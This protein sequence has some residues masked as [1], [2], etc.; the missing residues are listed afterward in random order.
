MISCVCPTMASRRKWLEKAIDCF[1]EQD[2]EEKEL[3]V[4][5]DYP[6]PFDLP[7]IT[8]TVMYPTT[9]PMASIG[10]KRNLGA[11]R[12][13]GETLL[14]WDDDDF[15]APNRITDQVNRLIETGKSVTGYHSLE[16]VNEAGRRWLYKGDTGHAADTSLCYRKSFWGKHP[17]DHI[18]DGAELEFKF[19]AIREGQFISVPGTG[20]MTA[21]IH[22]G[23]TTARVMTPGNTTW[24]EL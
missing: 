12:A 7:D 18:N 24:V 4:V 23:N 20:M 8:W 6:N 3:I 1:F 11:E 9:G 10:Y 14:S 19:A 15:S 13:N 16:F 22:S 5:A 2:W 21:S 17:F